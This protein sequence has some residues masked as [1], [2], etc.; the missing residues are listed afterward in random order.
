MLSLLIWVIF[1]YYSSFDRA[2]FARAVSNSSTTADST[3]FDEE[4]DYGSSHNDSGV[5]DFIDSPD[6]ASLQ[7]TRGKKSAPKVAAAKPG[8]TGKRASSSTPKKRPSFA[9]PIVTKKKPIMEEEFM[10]ITGITIHGTF[11]TR[12]LLLFNTFVSH[13]PSDTVYVDSHE[14]TVNVLAPSLM[15]FRINDYCDKKNQLHNG[16]Q[17]L[18]TACDYSAAMKGKAQAFL[19]DRTTV[20]VKLPAVPSSFLKHYSAIRTAM[21]TNHVLIDPV[22]NSHTTAISKLLENKDLQVVNIL[23]K[24]DRTG[25]ELTNATFTAERMEDDF[26][27]YGEIFPEPVSIEVT[28][29]MKARE[30]QNLEMYVAFNIGR[31][32]NEVRRGQV[33]KPKA[34]K[35]NLVASSLGTGDGDDDYDD[36]DW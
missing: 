36:S 33:K 34:R 1:Y 22:K 7:S 16:Y 3:Q 35:K 11:F 4:S 21:E 2:L 24:F 17:L 19:V 30:Y 29:N 8:S 20:L 18:I 14:V 9:S 15:V 25:E 32:E 27:E 23:V 26:E 10:D 5:E 6:E 31:I 28:Q 12:L 13:T